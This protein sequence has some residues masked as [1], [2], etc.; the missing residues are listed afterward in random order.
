MAFAEATD[1]AKIYYRLQGEG[2]PLLLCNASFA[3]HAHWS[4]VEGPLAR[5]LRVVSWDYRGHGRSEAPLD[6]DRYSLAQVVADLGAVHRAAVE[7]A[8]ALVGGLSLGGLV[9]LSYALAHPERVRALLLFN[10]GPGFKKPEALA[11]WQARLERAAAKLEEVGLSAYLDGR[12]AQAE[13]LGR[14][15]ASELAQSVR[16]SVLD[17]SVGGLAH[18]ARNVAGPVPNLVDRLA[19][20][21]VPCLVVVGEHDA[22]FQRASEVMTAKLPRARRVVLEGAGHALQL[23]RPGAFVREVERFRDGLEEL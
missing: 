5:R 23:D 3:T 2:L 13:L 1:G 18:F 22:A 11:Q 7:N 19:E 10:T 12:R 17:S 14:E 16:A 6:K 20:I 21:G 15:P 4:A 9:A 8:P